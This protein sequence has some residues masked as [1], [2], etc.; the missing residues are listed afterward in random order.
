MAICVHFIV[1]G[2]IESVYNTCRL[3]RDLLRYR[4]RGKLVLRRLVDQASLVDKLKQALAGDKPIGVIFLDVVKFH[5]IHQLQG[6]IMATR[7]LFMLEDALRRKI[8]E[9]LPAAGVLAAEHLWADDF[10]V[11][12]ALEDAH[13]QEL[14]LHLAAT[15]RS[16]LKEELDPKLAE[17]AGSELELHLGCSVIEPRGNLKPDLKL[18]HALR[19][20]QRAA[21][22][23]VD[24]DTLRLKRD[25]EELLENKNLRIQYQPVVSL[26]SG[27]ILGWEALARGPKDSHFSRPDIIFSFAEEVGLLFPTEKVCREKAIGDINGLG[28]E[29]K[30]FL[31]VHPRTMNDP[32]FVRGETLQLLQKY[33]LAPRNIVFEIT[34][35][36]SIKDYHFLK[37]VVEHYR[38]QGYRIAIDD[39]GAGFSGLQSIAEIRPDFIKID[40]SLVRDID[41][42]PGRQAVV[43]AL[44][45]LAG[46]INSRVIA[47]GVETENELNV[48][49]LQGAH[50]AQGYFLARPGFPEPVV[51]RA[52]AAYIRRQRIGDRTG[53][54]RNLSIGDLTVPALVAGEETPVWKVKELLD[55][56]K[57]PNSSLLVVRGPE[58]VGLVM[59]HNLHRIL[60]SQYG[61]PLYYR[62]PVTAVVDRAPLVLDARISL[63]Q[64][65]EL[66]VNR[67]QD[68][69]YDDLVVVGENRAL[70]GVVP[71]QRLLDT[72][73]RMQIELAKG[74][75]PLTGLP[76][77]VAI[78]EELSRRARHGQVNSVI[79]ADLDEF[80]AYNDTYGFEHGDQMIML[81][82][83]VLLH[84][85]K[86]YGAE[87]DFAGHIG[88]CCRIEIPGIA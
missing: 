86:K 9:L 69:L 28:P 49:L 64:A 57:Q 59:R 17:L 44:I 30:L 15:L 13:S 71:V 67:A 45:S 34:E 82:S 8:A 23:T 52:M 31:N 2:N 5:E 72:V 53:R 29:Q 4:P 77:N 78:E 75:N 1:A 48:L 50:Y 42:N 66:A 68:K 11:L 26:S 12:V 25:F 76:G 79:Y 56:A 7:V 24:L 63:E 22:G 65:A 62:R 74:A 55:A 38:G 37:R 21:K 70:V 85:T 46:K 47:E 60:S 84:S 6:S 40:M 33:G 80:K 3:I 27:E 88:L 16:S 18:Y 51:T 43:E 41:R 36:H 58:T 35:R 20:A 81:L 32:K 61:V 10:V 54:R 19:E 73:T 14:L 39:V 87:E 83:K